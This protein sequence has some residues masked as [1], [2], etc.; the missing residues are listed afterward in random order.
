MLFT[1]L[2]TAEAKNI[3]VRELHSILV[4]AGARNATKTRIN[5]TSSRPDRIS[6]HGGITYKWD[7]DYTVLRVI[8]WAQG[9][10]FAPNRKINAGIYQEALTAAGFVTEMKGPVLAILG[11]VGA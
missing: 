10:S 8:R 7:A 11:K 4:E 5:Y 2:E 6:I 1:E 3:L 9:D